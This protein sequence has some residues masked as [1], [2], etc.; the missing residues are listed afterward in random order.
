MLKWSKFK[1]KHSEISSEKIEIAPN[2]FPYTGHIFELNGQ[3]QK[4][5][6]ALLVEEG[7][8]TYGLNNILSMTA[9]TTDQIHQVEEHLGSLANNNTETVKCVDGVFNDLVASKAKIDQAWDGMEELINHMGAVSN[10]FEDFF[11]LFDE[12]KNQY[13]SI[14]N[15]ASIITSIASQTNMLS[16]NATIEAARVGEAGKG[17]AVVANE[18]KKL[19]QD[20]QSSATDIMQSLNDMTAVMKKLNE[21]SDEGKRVVMD[22]TTMISGSQE[23]LENIIKAE[24]VVH[25]H[26]GI[27]KSS[28]DENTMNIQKL[29]ENMRN[30]ADKSVSENKSLEAL[31]YGIQKKSD[32]Y[33]YILNHLNQIKCLEAEIKV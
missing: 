17:F 12:L 5:V 15:L 31:I 32:Y 6:E 4:E 13:Q 19:S 16:L 11:R 26:L 1:E 2:D 9:Y 3:L 33:L 18:I 7:K 27:V 22:T 30:V 10:V 14:G 8:M 21:K 23:L 20:T 25:N 28:Q 24:D 29:S